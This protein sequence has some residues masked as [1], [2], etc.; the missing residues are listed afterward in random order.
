M[1]IF[2]IV[3]CLSFWSVH[4]VNV[5]RMFLAYLITEIANIYFNHKLLIAFA[6][7]FFERFKYLYSGHEIDAEHRLQLSK[8]NTEN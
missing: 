7:I 8:Y 3:S 6:I 1:K 4:V 2:L 5:T